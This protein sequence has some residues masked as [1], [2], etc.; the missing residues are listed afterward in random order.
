MIELSQSIV[1]WSQDRAE[2]R[3][4]HCNKC[5][6]I[7]WREIVCCGRS[8][9]VAENAHHQ[10]GISKSAGLVHDAFAAWILPQLLPCQRRTV[11]A[12][13][14]KLSKRARE[15]FEI[16]S[17]CSLAGGHD[18]SHDPEISNIDACI[19][20]I[21]ALTC[22]NSRRQKQLQ[23]AWQRLPQILCRE[24]STGTWAPYRARSGSPLE[25]KRRFGA[26][27]IGSPAPIVGAAWGKV[28]LPLNLSSLA[29]NA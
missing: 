27:A 25:C 22:S 28:K 8:S 3:T 24:G 16:D 19:G 12:V 10:V 14:A 4:R 17:L 7:Q 23:S 21:C 11:S 29:L 15:I 5:S 2:T 1:R 26:Q 6:P 18:L 13:I 9:I 20:A